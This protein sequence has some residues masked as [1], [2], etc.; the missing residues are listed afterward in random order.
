MSE[1]PK[2]TTT[3]LRRDAYVYVRQSTPIQV[4]EHTESL[5][6]Q[7]ELAER[8][9]GFGWQAH[10][11]FVIDDDLGR[12]GAETSARAGFRRLVADVALRQVGLVLGIEASRLARRNVT[13]I[14]FWTRAP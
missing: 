11:V 6:R 9:V 8:T 4:R 2:I 10:Q 7:Y 1:F 13:G 3:D 14:T 5:E 12:S